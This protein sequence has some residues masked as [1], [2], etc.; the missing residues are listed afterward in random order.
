MMFSPQPPKLKGEKHMK[1]LAAF[2]RQASPGAVLTACWPETTRT[3]TRPI[4]HRQTNAIRF[5]GGSWLRFPKARETEF[6]SGCMVIFNDPEKG[7]LP[8]A[9]RIPLLVYAP[10]YAIPDSVKNACREA[11]QKGLEAQERAFAERQARYA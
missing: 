6:M 9:C 5:E 11:L 3:A 8:R 7:G 10:G 4:E 2:K 1:N